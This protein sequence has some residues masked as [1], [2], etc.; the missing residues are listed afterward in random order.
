M[1]E[2]N[3]ENQNNIVDDEIDLILRTVKNNK[4]LKKLEEQDN[5]ATICHGIK[6]NNKENFDNSGTR[7]SDIDTVKIKSTAP[8]NEIVFEDEPVKE[9]K[10]APKERTAPKKENVVFFDD[11]EDNGQQNKKVQKQKKA[12]KEQKEGFLGSAYAGIIKLV[13]YIA[14]ICVSVYY[15]SSTII[16]VANDMFAFVKPDKDITVT[17]P[18]GATTQDIAEI[19]EKNEVIQNASVFK[20]YTDLRI[21]KSSSLN[22]KFLSGSVTLNSNMNYDALRSALA[23][24]KSKEVVKITFPEGLTVNETIDLLVSNGIGTKENYIDAIQNY[25]Y[26]NKIVQNIEDNGYSDYRK[27]ENFSYRLEGYLFP[28]TYEFFNDENAVSVIDKF[29]M[30]FERKFDTAFYEVANEL[31]YTMDEI[32]TIA[33]LIEKEVSKASEYA[34]VSSVFHNRLNNKSKYPYLNSDATIQYA[35]QE[36][37]SA[38][39]G[40]DTDFDHPYNTYINK[41]LPPGP[42]CNP[43]YEAIVAALYPAQTDYYYFVTGKDGVTVFSKTLSEHQKNVDR[44]L[45]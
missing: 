25:E 31:G 19:L 43:S 12:Q 20:M 22:G 38:L 15:L 9:Y 32:I 13:L 23:L 36:R 6:G 30:N 27:D 5:S 34:N 7:I 44:L 40:S 21:K 26:K 39:S 11:F 28:D 37:K 2:K 41:G 18:E 1:D 3:K 35:L 42:I 14:F 8:K 29:L 33:S 24:Y 4:H 16:N 45:K 10:P 17:I